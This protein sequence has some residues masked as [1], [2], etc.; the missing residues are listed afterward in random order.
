MTALVIK[1]DGRRVGKGT[2]P[3]IFQLH[4]CCHFS[5]QFL[6]N[7]T[8]GFYSEMQIWGEVLEAAG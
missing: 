7:E 1:A 6:L 8:S 4:P 2:R 3:L 5:P